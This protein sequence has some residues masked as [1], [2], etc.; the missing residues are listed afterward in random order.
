[1]AQKLVVVVDD[2]IPF[3]KGALEPYAEV[4]YCPGD[5]INRDIIQ[6]ADALLVRTRTPC[7]KELLEGSHVRFVGTA[8]AGSDH[9]DTAYLESA[10]IAWSNAPACNA[11]SVTQYVVSALL[12]LSRRSRMPLAGKT[13]GIIGVGNV[14]SRVMNA[15]TA[16]GMRTLLCDPLRAQIEG[17]KNFW[18]VMDMLSHCDVVTLHVPLNEDGPYRTR[19]LVNAE[20]LQE[21]HSHAWLI[22][23]SRGSVVDNAALS[24][25]LRGGSIG[26]AVLDV[27]EDEPHLDLGLLSVVDI[28]TAHIAGYSQDGK[29]NATTQV[30]QKMAAVLNIEALKQFSAV[31]PADA[32]LVISVDALRKSNQE[33]IAEV[34]Q[35]TYDIA[36]DNTFLRNNVE[37]FDSLRKQY[38]PR[39]EPFAYKVNLQHGSDALYMALKSLGFSVEL[40]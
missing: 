28:G 5:K 37:R 15:A 27:W 30:V 20:F 14:G 4:R 1:M 40:K 22:N 23:A 32:S 19:R 36:Q 10:G 16:L 8:T 31:P 7:N 3:V 13:L 2:A 38:A 29:A 24:V 35:Q 39:R 11:S 26:G 12:E 18:Y 17:K 25:A 34:Y 9:L 6:G 21:M 33:V